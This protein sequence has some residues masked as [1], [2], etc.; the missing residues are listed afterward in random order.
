MTQKGSTVPKIRTTIR[1]TD[2][3]DVSEQE[4]TDL[5]R[6]GLLLDTNATTEA[7]L[8]NAANRQTSPDS[9]TED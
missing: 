5:G 8:L 9:I 1:P 3:L 4:A 2:E 6:L 7:G